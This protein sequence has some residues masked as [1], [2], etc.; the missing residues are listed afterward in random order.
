MQFATVTSLVKWFIIHF[1]QL[2]EVSSIQP[3]IRRTYFGLQLDEVVVLLGVLHMHYC[4]IN[5]LYHK[6][7][8]LLDYLVSD[9]SNPG[10]SL[11]QLSGLSAL[12]FD[13]CINIR[14]R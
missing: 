2:V 12:N 10:Q 6:W 9:Y 11:I 13:T 8:K 1:F 5:P 4:T 7:I 14:V 3:V